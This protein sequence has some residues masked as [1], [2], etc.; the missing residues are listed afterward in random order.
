MTVVPLSAQRVASA[1]CYCAGQNRSLGLLGY[2]NECPF[3]LLRVIAVSKFRDGPMRV[4]FYG[5]LKESSVGI[6]R[7]GPSAVDN[8]TELCTE[9]TSIG[10]WGL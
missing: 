10:I 7:D 1:E 8:S 3:A 5:R 6:R 4:Q 9:R 2:Q